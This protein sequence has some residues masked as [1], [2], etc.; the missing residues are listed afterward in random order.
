MENYK[1]YKKLLD[2]KKSK[3]GGGL[4]LF[5]N[6]N[7]VYLHLSKTAGTTIYKVLKSNA[8]EI[9]VNEKSIKEVSE[10]FDDWFSFIVVRNI[11][12]K[13]LSQYNHEYNNNLHN[14]DFDTWMNLVNDR[15]IIG[16]TDGFCSD[17]S[18]IYNELDQ[19]SFCTIDEKE[20]LSHIGH[21]ESLGDTFNIL[22]KKLNK[23]INWPHLNP[24]NYKKTNLSKEQNELVS[25]RFKKDIEYF[26]FAHD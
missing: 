13:I 10:N 1:I 18:D 9:A 19:K 24:T 16:N 14:Y 3:C 2:I 4:V 22:E 20:W 15:Q 8:T 23:K 7:I 11:F 25:R 5:K 21:F 17:Y 12:T 26:G 6:P